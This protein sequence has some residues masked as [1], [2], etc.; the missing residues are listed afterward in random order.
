MQL[1]LIYK[2]LK[3]EFKRLGQLN[4]AQ[5]NFFHELDNEEWKRIIWSRVHKNLFWLG[6]KTIEITSGLIH[7]VARLCNEGGIP[8]NEK[9]VKN[10][11][12]HNTKNK[13]NERGM[14]LILIK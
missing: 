6:D 4:V 10:R 5:Y 14:M 3:E 9:N 12:Q 13:W 7:E 11:V 2:T 1:S 8:V